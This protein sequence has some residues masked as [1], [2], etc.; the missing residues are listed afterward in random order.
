MSVKALIFD[1]D[2]LLVDTETLHYN[3]WRSLYTEHG[4]ELKLDRWLLDLGTHGMFDPCEELEGLL[5]RSIDREATR[6]DRRAYHIQLCEQ[7]PLR[8]GILALLEAARDRGLRLAVATSSTRDWVERWLEHHQIRSYFSC[9]RNRDD[10][11]Q[12][13]PDPELFLSAAACLGIPPEEC[14]VLEDSPNGMRAAAAAGMRCI[15]VPTAMTATVDLP[16]VTL[17]VDDLT[18]WTLADLLA[19]LD[20]ADVTHVAT[21]DEQSI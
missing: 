20:E 12:V 11:S 3:T 1:F 15:A 9:V 19:R 6:S 5:G 18:T 7:E 4:V 21:E 17:R 2:G 13:K 10:V 14:V 16:P 8:P